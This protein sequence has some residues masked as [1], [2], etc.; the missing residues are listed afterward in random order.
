M[1]QGMKFYSGNHCDFC[2]LGNVYVF[3]GLLVQ[4]EGI[5]LQDFVTQQYNTGHRQD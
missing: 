3:T 1:M 2:T 4:R 5:Y